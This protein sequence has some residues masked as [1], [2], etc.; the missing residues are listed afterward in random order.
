M[1]TDTNNLY[2]VFSFML[3][4]CLAKGTFIAS[5]KANPRPFYS[6]VLFKQGWWYYTCYY[7]MEIIVK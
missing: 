5:E 6:K 4:N 2:P 1:L 7:E 3:Q